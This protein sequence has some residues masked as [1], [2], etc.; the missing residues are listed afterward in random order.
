MY[1]RQLARAMQARQLIASRR[2]FL[3]RSPVFVGIKE[4]ATTTQE[5][6]SYASRRARTNPVGPA[7]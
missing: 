1:G 7:S 5:I 3:I 2:S 6:F 4:G